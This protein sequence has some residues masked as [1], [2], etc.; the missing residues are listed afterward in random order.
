LRA[1]LLRWCLFTVPA[2]VA[3]GFLS[4]RASGSGAVPSAWNGPAN[5]DGCA[6]AAAGAEAAGVV[7]RGPR[8]TTI[9]PP[10]PAAMVAQPGV[11]TPT[12]VVP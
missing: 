10:R 11:S 1:S 7:A 6:P 12:G 9:E 2:V 4:G 3:L 5:G 8:T